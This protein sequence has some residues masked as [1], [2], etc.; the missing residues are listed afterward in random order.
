M[1]VPIESV[2]EAQR[3]AK[4][5]LPKPVYVS[6]LAGNERGHTVDQNVAAFDELEFR[7]RVVADLPPTREMATTVLGQSIALPIIISPAAAQAVA[8]GGEVPVA[9]AAANAGTAIGQSNFA[10]SSFEEVAAANSKAFF[11]LYWAGTR[12]EI[13]ERVERMRRA[14]AAALIYTADAYLYSKRDWGTPAIPQRIDLP[15]AIKYAPTALARPAWLLSFL[16]HGSIPNLKVPNM[17]TSSGTAPTLVEAFGTW[18]ETPIPTWTDIA[19]IRE[20]W[21]GPFMVKGVLNPD[22]AR[23]AVD[24]GASAIS[25]SNHGGN[26]LDSSPATIRA[27]PAVVEAVGDQVEVLL[28]GGVRRGNDVAKALALG[29]RAVLVGRP[30]L[31]G[32]AAGGERGVDEVLQL[33]REGLDNALVHLGHRSIR[34]F[35]PEDL[36]IPTGFALQSSSRIGP[37]ARTAGI[38]VTS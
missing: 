12:D 27:L 33:F 36:I 37:L 32:L 1:R 34:E 28:D 21:G 24:I 15:T 10:S 3:Q 25:V 18:A 16:R 38:G 20:L 22:D 4:R 23:R 29:A 11:Q 6:L 17:A 13:A 19:W 14:G 26:A 9:R 8:P 5:R 31:F 30:W 35:G 2:A 7:S